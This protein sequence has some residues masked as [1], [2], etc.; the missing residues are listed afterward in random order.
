MEEKFKNNINFK[1]FNLK[2]DNIIYILR[3][4]I[5]QEYLNIILKNINNTFEYFYRNKVKITTIINELKL[6]E[7]YE[8]NNYLILNVFNIIYQ[9]NKIS[10]NIRGDTNNNLIL[11][12]SNNIKIEINLIKENITI[13]D[14]LSIIYNELIKRKYNN[15]KIENIINLEYLNNRTNKNKLNGNEENKLNEIKVNSI[16]KDFI[17]NIDIEELYKKID[18]LLIEQKKYYDNIIKEIKNISEKN[19]NEKELKIKKTKEKNKNDTP[20]DDDIEILYKIDKDNILI[21]INL[22]IIS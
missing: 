11:E 22:I 4:E 17:K 5:K 3:F 7:K 6:D 12:K 1:E 2:K 15:N 19:F 10:I 21:I 9:K 20:L 18:E 8:S 14:K 13:D 16:T